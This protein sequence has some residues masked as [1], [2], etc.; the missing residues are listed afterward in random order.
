MKTRHGTD[1]PGSIREIF[2]NKEAEYRLNQDYSEP[3]MDN[4]Q[5]LAWFISG[6]GIPAS[7]ID[8]NFGTQIVV[9]DPEFKFRL[10]I[11]STGGGDTHTH[12][13]S[14]SVY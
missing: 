1:L 12:L 10:V 7:A 6:V 13:Y 5:S 9:S 3:D 14:V 4:V 2:E 8:E 11:D